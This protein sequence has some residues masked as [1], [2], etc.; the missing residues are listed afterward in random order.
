MCPNQN[1]ITNSSK[2]FLLLWSGLSNLTNRLVVVVVVADISA[3]YGL[4]PAGFPVSAH[5]WCTLNWPAHCRFQETRFQRK[6]FWNKSSAGVNFL[7]LC[8]P[9]VSDCDGVSLERNLNVFR[10]GKPV[11]V[12]ESVID[13]VIIIIICN[14]DWKVLFGIEQRTLCYVG[15]KYFRRE[16]KKRARI[17][18]NLWT[19]HYGRLSNYLIQMLHIRNWFQKRS[20]PGK[21]MKKAPVFPRRP[22]FANERPVIRARDKLTAVWVNG[23]SMS[24]LI[25]YNETWSLARRLRFLI[26][27]FLKIRRVVW[28][29]KDGETFRPIRRLCAWS[30]S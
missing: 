6:D 12:Q 3:H 25:S 9:Y 29:V 23:G 20:I 14:P 24:L 30:V 7:R 8:L 22:P 17:Q 10:E 18:A 28:H 5:N 15:T 21:C 11:R 4:R 2:V 13:N 26:K 1:Q 27:T 19:E 16:K